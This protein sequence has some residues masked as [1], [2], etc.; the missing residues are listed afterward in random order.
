MPAW[1]VR[2]LG[3]VTKVKATN[4]RRTPEPT[5]LRPIAWP[6]SY[7][8]RGLVGSQI[9]GPS[10][11]HLTLRLNITYISLSSASLA[12]R[13]TAERSSGGMAKASAKQ[14]LA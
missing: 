8:K 4:D 11:H 6:K 1:A 13:K 5:V 14:F 9:F 10:P 3:C 2:L 7:E 12:V